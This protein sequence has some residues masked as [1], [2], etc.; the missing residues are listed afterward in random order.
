MNYLCQDV[1]VNKNGG[2]GFKIG[3]K[4]SKMTT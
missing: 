2:H 3:L 4:L 1:C